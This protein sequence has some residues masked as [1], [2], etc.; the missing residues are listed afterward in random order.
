MSIE[1]LKSVWLLLI[2]FFTTIHHTLQVSW[3]NATMSWVLVTKCLSTVS[4]IPSTS[5][6]KTVEEILQLSAQVVI[7]V[8]ESKWLHESDEIKLLNCYSCLYRIVNVHICSL[9]RTSGWR[10]RNGVKAP[11]IFNMYGCK[12]TSVYQ[13]YHRNGKKEIAGQSVL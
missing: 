10:D 3:Q 7:G 6:K 1:R 2:T 4:P 9:N 11:T 8:R 13:G 12:I 5:W